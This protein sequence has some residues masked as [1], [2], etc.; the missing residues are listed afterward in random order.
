MDCCRQMCS[1]SV[2]TKTCPMAINVPKSMLWEYFKNDSISRSS[3]CERKNNKNRKPTTDKKLAIKLVTT[4][5]QIAF[6]E[7]CA[8]KCTELE[9]TFLAPKDWWYV[10]E[11]PISCNS[12]KINFTLI[13]EEW[14]S[15]YYS[16]PIPICG[17]CGT[18]YR[19]QIIL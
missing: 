17:G 1:L 10:W 4:S 14:S 2:F 18:C 6:T 8:Q 3:L 11:K 16:Q 19:H 13:A 5:R 7:K 12:K 15:V 9:T